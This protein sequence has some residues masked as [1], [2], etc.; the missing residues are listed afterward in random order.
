MEAKQNESTK[1]R[2]NPKYRF[3]SQEKSERL[4]SVIGGS[5]YPDFVEEWKR[6]FPKEKRIPTRPTAGNVINGRHSNKRIMEVIFKMAK[7]ADELKKELNSI[8]ENAEP[9][10]VKS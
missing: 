6:T 10:S 2:N 3:I 5:W 4:K 9:E 8:L 7:S 1:K